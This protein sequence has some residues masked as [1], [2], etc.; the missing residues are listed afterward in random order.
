ML[1]AEQI[2][3]VRL[4]GAYMP[5]LWHGSAETPSANDRH[6]LNDETIIDWLLS[7]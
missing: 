2:H 3:S 5:V 1:N 6:K 4:E 7:K